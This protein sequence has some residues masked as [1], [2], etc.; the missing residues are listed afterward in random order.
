METGKP[1]FQSKF[2][3]LPPDVLIT[4]LP[5]SEFLK[6]HAKYQ[7]SFGKALYA[8]LHNISLLPYRGE[9]V[10]VHIVDVQ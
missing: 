6:I 8:Y 9:H 3:K 4:L 7:L 10:P 5:W 1:V 2:I